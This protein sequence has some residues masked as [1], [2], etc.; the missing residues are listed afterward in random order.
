M[1]LISA[2]LD[3]IDAMDALSLDNSRDVRRH[4]ARAAQLRRIAEKIEQ[5]HPELK[6]YFSSLLLSENPAVR[7]WVAHHMLE[8][9][10]YGRE[11][12]ANALREIAYVAAHGQYTDGLG[13][14]MW[15]EDWYKEHPEDKAIQ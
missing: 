12:R 14:R 11:E 2:Y 3:T 1:D 13:N 6:A 10:R 9:M 8:V 5:H 7:I 4:N 15:L